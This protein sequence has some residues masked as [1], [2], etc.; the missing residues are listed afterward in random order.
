MRYGFIILVI[1]I[2]AGM[3]LG[4]RFPEPM[5]PVE[6]ENPPQGKSRFL[7]EW[8]G[9]EGGTVEK[10]MV[11]PVDPRKA[12]AV[13]QL[14]IWRT[15]DGANWELIEEFKYQGGDKAI[16]S[17]GG[18]H[19]I[20]ALE[21]GLWYT[22]DGGATWSSLMGFA[23]FACMSETPS[24]T[25][26]VVFWDDTL[27][28]IET[29]DGGFSWDTL[30]TL[31]YGWVH[32]V[33]FLPGNDSTIFLGADVG[34][35]ILI[36]RSLD[37]GT[38]WDTVWTED[39][40]RVDIHSVSDIEI[41]P[42]RPG[43]IFVSFGIESD[44]PTG[45]LYSTD[46]GESWSWLSSSLT[47][48]VYFPMDV[49]FKDENTMFVANLMP[50]GI[51]RGGR[52]PGPEEWVFNSVY[53]LTAGTTIETFSAD[54]IW[55]GTVAGV[56]RSTD[57]GTGWREVNS[58]LKAVSPFTWFGSPN[59]GVSKLVLNQMYVA[60]GF[61]NPIY[62]TEDGGQTWI[63]NFIP[64][65]MFSISIETYRASPDTAY[66][67]GLG[68]WEAGKQFMFHSL[69]RT[70]DGGQNWVP[71]DTLIAS[72]PDSLPFYTSLWVS[73]TNSLTLLA[74]EDEDTLLRSTDGGYTWTT[75]FTFLQYPPVGTDTVFVQEA[76]YIRVSYDAG[77]NW[78]PLLRVTSSIEAM[79][80]NPLSGY[81][82]AVWGDSLYRITLSGEA[83]P[84]LYIPSGYRFL[85]AEVANKLFLSYWDLWFLPYFLR[86][87]DYGDSFEIDTLDFLPSVLRVGDDEVI[88][89]DLGKSFWRSEDAFTQIYEIPVEQR[90]TSFRISPHLFTDYLEIQ[91]QLEKNALVKVDLYDIAGRKVK[92]ITKK[93]FSSGSHRFVC[94]AGE[95][96]QGVY[97]Y[98]AKIGRKPY[99]GKMVKI[100]P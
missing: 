76:D 55:A 49:E 62:K 51:Y 65:L 67:G 88:I 26:F 37:R 6:L 75:I 25:V 9:P 4:W 44:E 39:P 11:D 80:Y 10:I 3:A 74:A 23:D 72:S 64:D 85:N 2:L 82:F 34:D 31:P 18:D 97:F 28:L 61:G 96:S 92:A 89:G 70:T 79:S 48:L 12:Y 24:E 87:F 47:Y 5:S 35:T 38:T 66:L 91:L 95:L 29:V 42:W 21:D 53:S 93:V 7:W 63:R 22:P 45:L 20:A 30:S 1:L 19:A 59:S 32:A 83:T 69:Y 68:V 36:V 27:H 73:P 33:T 58:G 98:K 50:G 43:E 17:V 94:D 54:T 81:L 14:D 100:Q 99:S 71:L 77:E 78:D 56:I 84:L 57:G 40:V 15:P 86:S 52:V 41:N 16:V 60:N 46:G 13:T 8:T 90:G